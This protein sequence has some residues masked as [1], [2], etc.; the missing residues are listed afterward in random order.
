MVSTLVGTGVNTPTVDP[1]DEVKKLISSVRQE[2]RDTIA[3]VERRLA[4]TRE[5]ERGFE[6]GFSRNS[7]HTEDLN[8]RKHLIDGYT[9]TAN[10][11]S[12][13]SISWASLHVVYM[14]V[15][16][17][18]T[19]GNTSNK[20]A[21]FVKPASGTSVTLTTGNTMTTLGANDAL[22]FVNNSGVPSSVL[23]SS[24]PVA[25]ANN[26]VGTGSLQD[27]AVT[28]AKT[29][30]YT[31][32]T[33]AITNAQNK[34]DAAQAT[35]DGSIT[36]Y[37][38]EV[39]PWADGDAT[40]GGAANPGAKVGDLWY[41]QSTAQAYRWSGAA[42]TPAN[43]WVPIEDSDITAALAM[44][45]RK[46]TTYFSVAATAPTAP[47]EGF[48]IGDLWVVTDQG[49]LI[50]RWTGSAW[51]NV[52]FGDSALSGISGTKVGT[53]INGDYITSGTVVAAR[54]GSGV[55]GAVLNTATGTV[56]NTQIAANAVTPQKLNT[57]F[58]LLY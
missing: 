17:T 50:K 23:E 56:G 44:A 20:Y 24:I 12:A 4:Q 47:T 54:V 43:T 18:I 58:H 16:Y 6:S 33:T 51:E 55:N 25:V 42:G 22:I 46:T 45:G 40:C 5:I 1:M 3:D 31:T 29:D 52:Q 34:A 48:T 35:A 7:V 36:T 49:N 26:A 11:P 8:L 27:G 9:V 53:G 2:F 57:A 41:K 19:D 28:A 21:W 10:S 13:G 39:S 32:L 15:D 14:G 30:F 38:Q 37:W